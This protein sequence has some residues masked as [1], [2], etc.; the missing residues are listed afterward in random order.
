M[1]SYR[2]HLISDSLLI[3]VLN[4]RDRARHYLQVMDKSRLFMTNNGLRRLPVLWTTTVQRDVLT[5]IT[6][7]FSNG[8]RALSGTPTDRP[9]G[10][11]APIGGAREHR[12]TA[13]EVSRAFERSPVAQTSVTRSSVEKL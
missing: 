3:R 1:Y 5:L 7:N 4:G 8:E 13:R 9:L 6:G 2:I 11:T 10:P 12:S